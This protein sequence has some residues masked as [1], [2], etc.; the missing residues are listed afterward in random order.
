MPAEADVTATLSSTAQRLHISAGV[1]RRRANGIDELATKLLEEAT[2][3]R[4]DAQLI[5]ECADKLS[6]LTT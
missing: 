2:H 3:L 6:G 5:D 4:T 1:L